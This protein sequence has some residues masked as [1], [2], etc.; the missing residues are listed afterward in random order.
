MKILSGLEAWN[1][2][3]SPSVNVHNFPVAHAVLDKS[4]FPT[5][6]GTYGNKNASSKSRDERTKHETKF[7][8]RLPN[9]L[10]NF[11]SFKEWI[12]NKK[13]NA[14]LHDVLVSTMK[15]QAGKWKCRKDSQSG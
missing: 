13:A 6:F 8:S 4:I 15:G 12:A 3:S 10:M 14:W 11:Y 9:V 5:R 7:E 1:A 2:L